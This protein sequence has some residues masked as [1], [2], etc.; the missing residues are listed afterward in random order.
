MLLTLTRR[1]SEEVSGSEIWKVTVGLVG[2]PIAPHRGAISEMLGRLLFLSP[3]VSR[4]PLGVL[5]LDVSG[6]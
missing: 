6:S 1:R 4:A 2:S 3:G 5:G